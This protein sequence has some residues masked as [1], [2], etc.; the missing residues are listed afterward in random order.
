MHETIR[1]WFLLYDTSDCQPRSQVCFTN[2]LPCAMHATLLGMPPTSNFYTYS[3]LNDYYEEFMS[4]LVLSF[5]I[6]SLEC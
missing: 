3:F 2:D 4:N 5:Y 6:S 1:V